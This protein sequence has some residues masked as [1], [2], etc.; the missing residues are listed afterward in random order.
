MSGGVDASASVT[1]G[2]LAPSAV[3]TCGRAATARSNSCQR[4][5]L[6]LNAGV[7]TYC[8]NAFAPV[9][10]QAGLTDAFEAEADQ[11]KIGCYGKQSSVLAPERLEEIDSEGRAVLTQH[12]IR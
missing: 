12:A 4:D 3:C 10:A 11:G 6:V 5:D 2:S 8:K 1:N 9:R 7:A